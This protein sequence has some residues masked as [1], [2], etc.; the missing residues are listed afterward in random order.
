ML[1][2]KKIHVRQKT[3]QEAN[4]N[5][6]VGS[7]DRLSFEEIDGEGSF[8]SR[9]LHGLS[10]R[11]LRTFT[12]LLAGNAILFQSTFLLFSVSL[13]IGFLCLLSSFCSL[14]ILPA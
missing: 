6:S 10:K 11:S 9:G 1:A 5:P 4:G 14:K 7:P 8:G 13:L 3:R 12:L 2:H